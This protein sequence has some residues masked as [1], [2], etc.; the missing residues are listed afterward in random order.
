[1]RTYLIGVLISICTFFIPIKGFLLIMGGMVALD[2]T[3]AMYVAYKMGNGMK[4]LTSSKFFN[5]APK[6]FFYLG[7]MMLA[8]MVDYFIIGNDHL[9]GIELFG[10]KIITLAFVSNEIKSVNESY[11]KRFNKS[12]Y[13][14]LKE[15][16]NVLK[17]LKKDI[18]ELIQDKEQ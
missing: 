6:L 18:Q 15:Y 11:V 17:D 16:Y 3:F 12:I 5:I 14:T 2:T 9:W 8:Y 7:T 1:M 13:D 10:T 4:S